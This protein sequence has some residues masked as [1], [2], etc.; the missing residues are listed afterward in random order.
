MFDSRSI[1]CCS[2]HYESVDMYKA[3]M[4]IVAQQYRGQRLEV[5][6]FVVDCSASRSIMLASIMSCD[7]GQ[8]VQQASDLLTRPKAITKSPLSATKVST[9]VCVDPFRTI[10]SIRSKHPGNRRQQLDSREHLET[11]LI[12]IED[13]PHQATSSCDAQP[14]SPL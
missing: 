7:E 12:A 13:T 6:R 5:P 3:D 9:A 8:G 2:Q 10:A 1:R 14:T 11:K 4:C